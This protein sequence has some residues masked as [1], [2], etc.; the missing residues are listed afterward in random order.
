M[1]PSHLSDFGELLLRLY[2][3]SREQPLHLFQDQALNLVKPIVFFDSAMWGTAATA[4]PGGIDVHTLHLHEKS[5]QMMIDYEEFKHLDTAAASLFGMP[6]GTRAFN[7]ATWW[8]D[9]RG[10]PF[11]DFVQRYEQNN[12]LIT[13]ANDTSARFMEWISLFRA[14]AERQNTP[15]ETEL[16]ALLSPHLM[17]ALALN[18]VM[19]LDRLMPA[20]RVG[21]GAA[22]GDLMGVLYH[23]DPGFERLLREEWHDWPGRA[24]PPEVLD[25]FLRGHGRFVGRKLVLAHGTEHGLLFLAARPRAPADELSP[26]ERMVAQQLARGL[27]YKQI[28]QELDRSPATVRNQIRSIYEKL[29]VTNVAEL[30]EAL[31]QAD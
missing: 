22:M 13:M 18:R 19:H 7:T 11:R 6:R 26:R 29:S 2:R 21:R 27:T 16:V 31:R 14:D 8:G 24:L 5:P 15:A 3:L 30:V 1:A 4:P 17:Q 25:H 23:A 12:M 10:R 28:A 20:D 9:Q